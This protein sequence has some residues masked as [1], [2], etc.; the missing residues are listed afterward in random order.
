VDIRISIF[1]YRL[2][3]EEC[4]TKQVDTLY[5]VNVSGDWMAKVTQD[6]HGVAWP[7]VKYECGVV[8]VC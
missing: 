6:N 1:E 4:G 8:E 7:V 5:R 2:S 3:T